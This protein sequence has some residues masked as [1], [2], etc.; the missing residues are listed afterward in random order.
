MEPLYHGHLGIIQ[1]SPDNQG[2]LIFQVS[3]YDK[4]TFGTITK[5]VDYAGV[6]ISGVLIKRFH[7]SYSYIPNA[8]VIH[9]DYIKLSM[10]T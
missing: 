2:V 1:K 4:A 5:C 6:L 9:S 3:L 8:K 10:H 7:C